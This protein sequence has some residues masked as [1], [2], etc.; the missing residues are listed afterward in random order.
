[1]IRRAGRFTAWLYRMRKQ[2]DT[3]LSLLITAHT[4]HECQTDFSMAFRAGVRVGRRYP[5]I[6]DSMLGHTTEWNI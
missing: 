2:G 6:A 1:M 4:I 5:D 3:L